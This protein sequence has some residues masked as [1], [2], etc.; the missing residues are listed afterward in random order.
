MSLAHRL[1]KCYSGAVH[2]VLRARGLRNCTLPHEIRPLDMD[3]RLAGKVFTVNGHRDD[4][5]DEHETLLQWTGMLSKVPPDSVVVCQPNDHVLAHMGE[6]SAETFMLRGVRGYIVDGG[7]RD[8]Q[9]IQSIGFRIFCRY[10]TPLDV[11]GRWVPDA[12]GQPIRIAEV[13][14]HTGDYVLGDR[15]GVVIVPEKLA[16][17]VTAEAE[18]VMQ[19]ESLVR[20][21]ILEGVDPQ[22][23]YI[24]YGKF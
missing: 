20:K 8:T 12:L 9:F 24:K 23:A 11:V 6:L 17:E 18:Q 4:T 1:E 7:C 10:C 2:D 19:T 21:A 3:R 14:I 5:L 22:E 13:D 16:E 15:D